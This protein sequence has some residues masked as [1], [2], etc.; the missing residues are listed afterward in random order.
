MV[1]TARRDGLRRVKIRGKPVPLRALTA[2]RPLTL[3]TW[4]TDVPPY[5]DYSEL[6]QVFVILGFDSK[7]HRS[8]T[9]IVVDDTSTRESDRPNEETSASVG[10]KKGRGTAKIVPPQRCVLIEF[11]FTLSCSSSRQCVRCLRTWM[12][13]VPAIRR[14]YL[15]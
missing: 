15:A 8:E 12:T 13:Q 1:Y 11:Y 5:A 4:K 6:R 10:R 3:M 2:K 9:A 14:K 7:H